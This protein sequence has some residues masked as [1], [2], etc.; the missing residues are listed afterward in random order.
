M[1]VH[2]KLHCLSLGKPFQPGLMFAGKAGA[3]RSIEHLVLLPNIRLGWR[4]F[5]GT[6]ALV[7]YK[8]TNYVCKKVLKGIY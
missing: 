6:N 8:Y 5:S 7:Y 3:Y 4:G 2:N 1:F